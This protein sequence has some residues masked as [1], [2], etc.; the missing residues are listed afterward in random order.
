MIKKWQSKS[1]ATTG[2][3]W[4][5]PPKFLIHYW[6]VST[7]GYLCTNSRSCAK[8]K[9]KTAVKLKYLVQSTIVTDRVRST[10]EG[11]V[12][13]LVCPSI[14]LSTGGGGGGGTPARSIRGRGTPLYR[15]TDG[16]LDTPRS[17]CLLRSGRRTFL[18]YILMN[19]SCHQITPL[20]HASQCGWKMKVQYILRTNRVQKYGCLITAVFILRY[21]SVNT[22]VVHP[23]YSSYQQITIVK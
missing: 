12:L 14:C 4:L 9:K 13:T 22:H 21:A 2:I 18:F 8:K 17:V 3:A 5:S 20:L 16:V 1:K 6:C 11:Y 23:V 10:R 15:T 7:E 19:V